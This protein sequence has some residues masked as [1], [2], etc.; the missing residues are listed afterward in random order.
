[1]VKFFAR[2]LGLNEDNFSINT[3]SVRISKR[4]L[5]IQW[6]IN[7]IKKKFRIRKQ[8]YIQNLEN[9][10]ENDIITLEPVSK[11][12]RF[13]LLILN[14][15]NKLFGISSSNLL[16]WMETYEWD[17]IPKNPFTNL[18]LLKFERKQCL[19]IAKNFLFH[20]IHF[21][22]LIEEN[23]SLQESILNFSEKETYRRNPRLKIDTYSSMLF[24]LKIELSFLLGIEI[25]N[26]EDISHSD[27]Q[28]FDEWC[29]ANTE[30]DTILK[31]KGIGYM[32]QTIYL[33][34]EE[35]EQKIMNKYF[36]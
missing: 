26:Q 16:K 28:N 8:K 14:I 13:D 22:H 3:T 30:R 20:N 1:M 7:T 23:E 5:R 21:A 4:R 35:I 12:S 11:I 31:V 18:P 33:Q 29:H 15:N 24:S 6:K 25:I 17:E 34:I 36:I 19:R 10:D 32:I 2:T 9:K 27:L